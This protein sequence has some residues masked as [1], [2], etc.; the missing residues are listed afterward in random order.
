MKLTPD[1]QK[2]LIPDDSIK[3]AFLERKDI[4]LLPQDEQETRWEEHL[5]TVN[6]F[7]E[8]LSKWIVL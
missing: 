7:R 6:E 2:Q 4:A 1:E 8:M 3:S 5:N